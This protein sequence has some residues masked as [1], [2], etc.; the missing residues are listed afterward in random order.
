MFTK[1]PPPPFNNILN[2]FAHILLK[3]SL[4]HAAYEKNKQSL[5]AVIDSRLNKYVL[6]FSKNPRKVLK[7][8]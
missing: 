8:F 7:D 5:L 6:Y 4:R 1:T 3:N 2:F